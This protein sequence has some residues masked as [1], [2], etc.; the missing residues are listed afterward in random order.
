MPELKTYKL[1]IS[2]SWAYSD[3]YEK[4]CN[5]LGDASTFVYSNYSIPKDDPVHTKSD[6]VLYEAIKQQM[7]FCNVIIILAGVYSSYSK[8]VEK[9]ITIA[10][11]LVYKINIPI[12]NYLRSLKIY[13]LIKPS[14]GRNQQ[15][16][17]II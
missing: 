15:H 17:F 7:T 2:H 11:R 8:W 1:F 5:L 9:E 10:D 13:N 14:I 4:L 16:I 3:A 12:R 6:V